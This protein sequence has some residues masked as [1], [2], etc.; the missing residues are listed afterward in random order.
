ML[1]LILL[2]VLSNGGTTAERSTSG[3]WERA[4]RRVRSDLV[5]LRLTPHPRPGPELARRRPRGSTF[6][7]SDRLPGRDVH[8]LR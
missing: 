5:V 3:N 2:L 7:L 4:G 6:A 8:T 1:A